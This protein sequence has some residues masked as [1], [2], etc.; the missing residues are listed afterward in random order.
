MPATYRKPRGILVSGRFKASLEKTALH[1]ELFWARD[2]WLFVFKELQRI[3]VCV[4]RCR[5][6]TQMCEVRM[7]SAWYTQMVTRNPFSLPPSP[8]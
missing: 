2:G 5:V 3:W 6:G 4:G 8:K 7:A 1:M